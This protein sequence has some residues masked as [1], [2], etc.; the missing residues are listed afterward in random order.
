MSQR[1]SGSCSLSPSW[2]MKLMTSSRCTRPSSTSTSTAR[3]SAYFAVPSLSARAE[4]ARYFPNAPRIDAA[5]SRKGFPLSRE[6]SSRLTFGLPKS[7]SMVTSLLP[8]LA[9]GG[10]LS[11]NS[12]TV[13]ERIDP[14]A[15]GASGTRTLRPMANDAATASRTC[16]SGT[17]WRSWMA[18]ISKPRS[19]REA[20]SVAA[21]RRFS[22]ACLDSPR[23]VASTSWQ[24]T[25][26]RTRRSK[27]AGS[28]PPASLGTCQSSG[29]TREQAI[30]TPTCRLKRP[31]EPR[32][33]P[34]S[35]RDKTCSSW[36]EIFSSAPRGSSRPDAA[37]N[38][39]SSQN[40]PMQRTASKM[41]WLLICI[42]TPF[43]RAL[44][45]ERGAETSSALMA[46]WTA[47]WACRSGTTC[48]ASS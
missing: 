43:A 34:S 14:T 5:A 33:T 45:P 20:T 21:S 29:R 18:G 12:E 4:K 44:G 32:R 37:S 13:A 6:A 28:L 19:T 23:T 30:L 46:L 22:Q 26:R 7:S 39:L 10:G 17:S 41:F 38:I 24:L 47:E 40:L 25:Q 9:F 42:S 36:S 2:M 27:N 8:S 11:L 31:S 16:A 35:L 1:T 15:S 3:A 48:L